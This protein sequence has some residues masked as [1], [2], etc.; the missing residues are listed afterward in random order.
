MFVIVMGVSGSGKTTVGELLAARMGWPF[1]D[2]DKFH[3]AENVAK[4]AAG[5]PL[6]DT[7]RAG[8]LA[9]L[10]GMIRTGMARGESGVMACSALKE[11]YRD[12]L[13]VDPQQ[14]QFV[15][16]KGSFD[17]IWERMQ[18]RQNH[19]MKAPMLQSQFDT[20]EEPVDVLTCDIT[21]DPQQIVDTIVEHL[22]LGRRPA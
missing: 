7:D 16:L 20:L 17:L 5:T 22:L 21:Q 4:M 11:Q 9:V 1:Y 19:Y 10:A 18:R 15:Y 8:W 2:G 14:V 3:P 13:R 12:S 6:D